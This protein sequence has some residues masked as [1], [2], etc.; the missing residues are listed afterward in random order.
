MRPQ[1]LSRQQ[2]ATV[3][4]SVLVAVLVATSTALAAPPPQTPADTPTP[5]AVGILTG[6]LLNRTT[7]QPVPHVTVRLRR[8]QMEVEQPP[9]TIQADAQG[10]FRFDGLDV[11]SHA[12][13]RAEVDYQGITFHSEFVAFQ[14]GVTQTIAPIPVYETTDRSD[15]VTAQ[16][17]HFIIMAREPGILSILELYQFANQAD[18][19][20]VGTLNTNGQRETMR[21]ALPPGAQDLVL[22][23]GTLGVDFLARPG[24]LAATTPLLPGGETFDVAFVYVVPYNTPSLA[25]D[26]PL[27]Y[28]TLVV[29]GLLMDVGAE[30]VSDALEFVGE[31]EAQGQN[32]LQFNGRNIKADQTLPILLQRLDNIRFANRQAVAA[33]V[34]TLASDRLDHSTM[35][36]AMLGLGIVVIALGGIYPGV[37]RRSAAPVMPAQ[38]DARLARER[39]LLT[40]VR[41]DEAYEAGQINAATYRRARAH[42]KDELSKLWQRGQD[43][44]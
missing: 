36:L 2:I 44:L 42:R 7:Q 16:R 1:S 40:L 18:R 41:L 12:F 38:E 22:Q 14:T 20:Y 39:L 27:H 32:F 21:I 23:S 3:A 28:D 15:A 11:S 8:W 35:M 5:A 24:E 34:E 26:R 33:D 4:A 10:Q 30:L 13:Y 19:A 37:R 29:N 43:T 17:F 9:L 31:R 25:L 6:Q